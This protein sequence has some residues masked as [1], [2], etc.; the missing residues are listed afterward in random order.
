MNT[1]IIHNSD[2]Q[3]IGKNIKYNVIKS[4]TEGRRVAIHVLVNIILIIIVIF[5]I[6]L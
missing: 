1:I 2:V 4:I 3:L 5:I 6:Y